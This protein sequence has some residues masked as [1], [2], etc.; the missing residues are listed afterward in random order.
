MAS[1][2]SGL[3]VFL[4]SVH[5]LIRGRK[6][7]LGRDSDTG[8]QTT[9]VVE[10]A[11]ALA[12]HPKVE[13]V[14]VA[15]RLIEAS[16]VDPSYSV[17]LEQIAPKA[18]VLRIP[19][20][21]K[22]YLRKESL[23]P[24]LDGFVDKTVNYFRKVRRVPD[25]VHGHY[26]DAGYVGSQLARLLGIPFVFTGHS[27]GRVK[28]GLLLEKGGEADAL[29]QRYQFSRRIEA[30]ETA[31][32]TAAL[33]VAST[34]QEIE[35]QYALYDH[36]E[37]SRMKV[38]P[39]GVDL[40]RFS[41]PEP[42]SPEPR[43]AAEVRRFLREPEKPMILAIARP[44]ERK[45]L[46]MLASAFAESE[47]LRQRANLV[48]LAGNR[49]NVADSPPAARRTFRVLLTLIDQHDLYG[50][51][52]YPKSHQPDDVPDLYRLAVQ[53]GGVF[54]NPALTEPFGLTLIE[55]AASGLPVVASNDGGPRDIIAACKHGVLVDPQ[56]KQQIAA[57]I[58][59]T[60]SDRKQWDKKSR[61]GVTLAHQHYSWASHT[62]KYVREIASVR[63]RAHARLEP[64]PQRSRLMTADRILVTGLDD[65]LTGDAKALALL[66][67]RLRKARNVGFAIVTGRSS[68]DSQRIIQ[69]IGVPMPDIL[70]AS[71]GSE[72]Y[73]GQDLVPDLSW[74]RHIDYHWDR[75]E[76][77]KK[78][79]MLK[80][81]RLQAETEQQHFKVSYVV[82][83]KKAPNKREVV[84]HLRKNGLR[85][86]VN[87]SHGMF[88]DVL[89][90]RASTGLAIRYLG[91]KWDI[92]SERTLVAGYA[93][94]DEDMLSGDTLGVIGSDF[95][96]EL[97]SLRGR[98]RIYFAAKSHAMGVL[99][100]IDRYDFFGAINARRDDE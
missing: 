84:Q 34:A 100:G 27:L 79:R 77:R 20:G 4:V 83:K 23:W 50:S 45:N 24:Y 6:L 75:D 36:Y 92:P 93:S 26:A 53:T 2:P 49:G 16:N 95:S 38:M 44:D 40:G 71:V 87:Y 8:G 74:Q 28:K 19:C 56:N 1:T 89:P 65:V 37:P 66:V 82:A 52:A 5:G 15:T 9:Y 69:T 97:G 11:R 86:N 30:E 63:R 29:E 85:V 43:I 41:P 22:R 76:V 55:A 47:A 70:V 62:A 33:V 17:P 61:N 99:E 10:L 3:Y 60:I 46:P 13:R 54:V 42:G 39:P 81:F 51:I 91:F 32:D 35:E 18:F 88:V 21:P 80:G 78:M 25:I 12:A 48:I 67:R 57:A 59:A 94:L 7:E 72:I 90:I 64:R 14:D 98:P 31:L 58:L 73:Y 96:P 68:L